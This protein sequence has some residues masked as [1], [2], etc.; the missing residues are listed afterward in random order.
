MPDENEQT[1]EAGS[2]AS[3]AFTAGLIDYAG[4]FPPAS[5]KLSEAVSN[6]KRYSTGDNSAILGDFICPVEKLREA[7][8]LADKQGADVR[9][10]ALPHYGG[11]LG[12]LPGDF[13]EAGKELESFT[14]EFGVQRIGALELKL[15]EETA[16]NLEE[17]GGVTELITGL[18]AFNFLFER[19]VP[20]YV[21]LVYDAGQ[22]VSPQW[23]E[24]IVKIVVVLSELRSE[25]GVPL[26][27]KLRCGG[28]RAEDVPSAAQVAFAIN[29]CREAQLP[30]K[31]TA[32]L[33][34][35]AC[36]HN[37]VGEVKEHG[38]LNVFGAAILSYAIELEFPKLV[39][40]VQQKDVSK[41]SFGPDSMTLGGHTVSLE[42]VKK[43]RELL[44]VGFGSCSFE[45]PIDE[46]RKLS[47]LPAVK[48]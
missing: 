47:I 36:S 38:F 28:P 19:G 18:S 9:F 22:R 3:A 4:L 26:G 15:S 32:G 27:F 42:K 21:E 1:G 8:A 14:S 16:Q 2:G 13:S 7:R 23:Q 24:S 31:F 34:K 33:H 6:F 30:V 39:D 20:A 10:V 29:Q 35:A 41:I 5:L 40:F 46:L 25:L 11:E 43:A 45:E 44:A 48:Q 37:S 17:R 12:D